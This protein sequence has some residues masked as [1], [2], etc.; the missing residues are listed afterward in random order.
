VHTAS[1]TIRSPCQNGTLVAIQEPTL[2]YCYHSGFTVYIGLILGAE[3]CVVL[4]N[5][6]WYVPTILML[7][8]LYSIDTNFFSAWNFWLHV[9]IPSFPQSGKHYYCFLRFP[10][11]RMSSL[12]HKIHLFSDWLCSL[13][14]AD[15][16]FLHVFSC[17]NCLFLFSAA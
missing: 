13:S 8:Y 15:L 14:N 1:L 6:W 5:V 7:Y 12:V 3:Q 11:M 2:T 17:F 10:Y 9:F 16:S 4:T